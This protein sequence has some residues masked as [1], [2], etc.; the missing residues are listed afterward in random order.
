MKSEIE[1]NGYFFD[2]ILNWK[3]NDFTPILKNEANFH[4]RRST[5]GN[6]FA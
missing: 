6:S 5:R 2:N 3:R 4:F 1:H